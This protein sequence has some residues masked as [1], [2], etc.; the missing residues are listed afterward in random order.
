MGH[1][2]V[3]TSIGSFAHY[4][5]CEIINT[6]PLIGAERTTYGRLSISNR[7]IELEYPNSILRRNVFISSLLVSCYRF[8]RS[9]S[10]A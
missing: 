5:E 9:C 3:M 4:I 6:M 8:E 10:S 1:G 7:C 2:L